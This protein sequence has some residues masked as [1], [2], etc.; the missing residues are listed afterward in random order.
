MTAKLIADAR[1]LAD[2]ATPGP[3]HAGAQNDVM[4][5]IV[6]RAPAMN[7]DYPVHDADRTVLAAMRQ[8][9]RQ[10]VADAAFIAR[11]RTLVVELADALEVE[12]GVTRAAKALLDEVNANLTAAEDQRDRYRQALEQL[13]EA[14]GT[15]Q[16]RE[17]ARA[18]LDGA[19]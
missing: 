7:N 8:G 5:V 4:Y 19:P 9:G 12:H 18:A 1:G 13:T 16:A 14:R 3:W 11:A 2:A 6:G 17:V 15:A 10:E